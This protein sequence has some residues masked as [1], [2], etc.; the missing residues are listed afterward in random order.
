MNEQIYASH[1]ATIYTADGG[2]VTKRVALDVKRKNKARI[3]R[4]ALV[5]YKMKDRAKR[6]RVAYDAK[7]RIGQEDSGLALKHLSAFAVASAVSPESLCIFDLIA[8]ILLL[9]S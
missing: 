5:G 6:Y 9:D 3:D 8:S 2:N 4:A 1:L 7:R